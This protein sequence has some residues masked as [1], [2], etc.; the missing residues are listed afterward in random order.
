MMLDVAARI[1]DLASSP[2]NR[3]EPLL[4][5][6]DP[7]DPLTFAAVGGLLL[8]VVLLATYLPASRASRMD[9]TWALR[10]E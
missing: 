2:G 3:L 1:D 6:M 4:Y 8:T 9:P 5:G 7:V 10:T